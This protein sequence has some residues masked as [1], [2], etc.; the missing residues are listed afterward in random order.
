MEL[1]CTSKFGISLF[2]SLFF[3]GY[4][5]GSLL[6]KKFNNY[7]WKPALIFGYFYTLI[8]I[9]I[10]Q[11]VP[12][13]WVRYIG[14]LYL[15]ISYFRQISGFIL[16]CELSPQRFQVWIVAIILVFDN[17]SIIISSVWWGYVDKHTWYMFFLPFLF[18]LIF[19]LGYFWLPESPRYLY[20]KHNYDEARRTIYKIAAFNKVKIPSIKFKI[21][22]EKVESEDL[23]TSFTEVDK[24]PWSTIVWNL[25]AVV[26]IDVFC[27]FN[28]YL[29]LYYTKYIGGI[30]YLNNIY[31]AVGQNIAMITSGFLQKW[32]KTRPTIIST[33]IFSAAFGSLL[34]I[35]PNNVTIIAI[36]VFGSSFGT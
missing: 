31:S 23:T 1:Y 27:S 22:V 26:L 12:N 21:E 15:G 16:A 20:E 29:I 11:F 7:G 34:I 36:G 33:L 30:V 32:F 6:L 19:G 9:P 8:G 18:L 24:Q 14:M 28:I 25:I 4:A 13:V 2:S 5:L 35:F 10:V 3:L 17:N